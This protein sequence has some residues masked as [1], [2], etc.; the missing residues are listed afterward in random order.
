MARV[1]ITPADDILRRFDNQLKA[2]GE[3]DARKALA[4]AINRTTQS[5]YSR[6]VRAIAKQSSI[7]TAIVRKTVKRKLAAHNS[8][9]LFGEI[10]AS[11]RPLSLKVFGAKQFSFGVRAKIYGEWKRFPGAFIWG[12]N[13]KSGKAV[14]GG[15]VFTNTRMPNKLSGRDNAL[16][17]MMT[18][19]SVAEELVK[20]EAVR[21]FNHLVE[22]ML[23]ARVSHELSRI[24]NP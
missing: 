6:V 8:G 13:Y 23:P 15:H 10:Y 17:E 7:P 5:A 14:A 19:P 3:T 18:G 24:L 21:V 1:V 4:R 16:S 12:G 9:D 11:G 2:A 22:T 20:D